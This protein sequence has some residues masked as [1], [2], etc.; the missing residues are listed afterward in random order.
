MPIKE[1]KIASQEIPPVEGTPQ[2]GPS[3]F[4][5]IMPGLAAILIVVAAVAGGLAYN[6][7]EKLADLKGDPEKL[8]QME[9]QELLEKVG[10]LIVL[11]TD[12]QPT[13]ATVADPSKL[14]DQ[15]FFAKAQK[16]DKVLIYTNAR[17]AILYNPQTNK[18]VEVAP[19]NIGS[20]TAGAST[21]SSE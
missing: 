7:K 4:H 1:T 5:K 2:S 11:P 21:E 18:I 15:A 12:E 8:A 13:V 10:S 17:K 3:L 20:Q 19:V 14:Q 9:T 6:Y 16:G